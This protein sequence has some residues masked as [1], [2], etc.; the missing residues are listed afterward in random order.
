MNE[1]GKDEKLIMGIVNINDDSYFCESRA[2]DPEAIQARTGKLMEEGA[3]IIDI[4][5]CSTR[6]GSE[7]I[8]EEDE[9]KRIS[10]AL[11]A[12]EEGGL[13]P[14]I[15]I[16][17]FRAGIV[18]KVYDRIGDFIV[19][20]ISAGEE[21]SAMLAT[22]GRLQLDYVAMHK[23]GTPK[24]MQSLCDYDDVVEEIIRYFREF[25]R[26]AEENGLR[27]WIL[28]PGFG[29]AKT[30]EQNYALLK[31]LPRIKE[32][33]GRKILVGISRKSMI[34]KYLQISTEDALP[35]TSALHLYSLLG[36]AD[37]LRVHDVKE[38]VEVL[39]LYKMLNI[40]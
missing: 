4:G 21:D 14:R 15:S 7:Y 24:T 38:A 17:T 6:P 10:Q 27:S 8:S 13:H 11:E 26:K 22:V 1:K 18:Q 9:W 16:D 19:N 12:L 34:T 40:A 37:I 36:G 32:A 3:D 2:L 20:D 25:E 28:D 39:K 30:V 29:F 35:A 31:Q 33:S 5:A 23:R